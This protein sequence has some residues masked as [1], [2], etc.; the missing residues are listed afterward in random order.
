MKSAT[1]RPAG[2]TT[3]QVVRPQTAGGRQLWKCDQT[4]MSET[5]IE[6]LEPNTA[7][8]TSDGHVASHEVIVL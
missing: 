5:I 1:F 6:D 7:A 3:R 4:K 8:T 2:T